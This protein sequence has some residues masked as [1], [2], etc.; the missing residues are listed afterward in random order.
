MTLHQCAC[1]API[2]LAACPV[3]V[4]QGMCVLSHLQWWLL[5]LG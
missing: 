2:A 4:T 3:H 1:K 5:D